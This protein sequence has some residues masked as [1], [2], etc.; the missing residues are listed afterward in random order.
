MELGYPECPVYL[1]ACSY[2]QPEGE[3]IAVKNVR[4]N[5]SNHP[6][7]V[8][9]RPFIGQHYCSASSTGRSDI[10]SWKQLGIVRNTLECHVYF[11]KDIICGLTWYSVLLVSLCYR[12][13]GL[14]WV[15]KWGCNCCLCHR[16][17]IPQCEKK[18]NM[19]RRYM[20]F[21]DN[22]RKCNNICVLLSES[23]E[24]CCHLHKA[25][26]CK[27]HAFTSVPW[28]LKKSNC[29]VP[30]EELP[31]DPPLPHYTLIFS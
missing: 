22:L 14:T 28:S 31:L 24:I 15:R 5:R 3:V 7:R 4:L 1:E 11:F 25:P 16:F 6:W 9:P 26:I 29:R 23:V 8:D 2:G 10:Q 12:P 19:A 20:H 13:S 18:P 27:I 17:H 30:T 21:V